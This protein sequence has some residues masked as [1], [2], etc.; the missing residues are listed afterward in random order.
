MSSV[1]GSVVA[2]I[3]RP[4]GEPEYGSVALEQECDVV[5]DSASRQAQA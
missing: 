3:Y 1:C 5:K 4:S 2:H